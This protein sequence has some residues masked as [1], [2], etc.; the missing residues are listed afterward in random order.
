MTRVGIKVT[1]KGQVTLP[2]SIREKLNIKQ[3]DELY[4]EFV[5]DQKL[6]I[7]LRP[8]SLRSNKKGGSIVAETAGLW[9]NDDIDPDYVD[10]LR[11]A[12][13]R[14]LEELEDFS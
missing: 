1:S 14:R 11:K 10:E 4:V 3:G 6:V 7:G 9:K 12:S 2:K 8:K 13:G 5:D